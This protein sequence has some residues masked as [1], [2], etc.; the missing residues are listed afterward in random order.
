MRRL[1]ALIF[2]LVIPLM[3]LPAGAQDLSGLSKQQRADT[4]RFAVNN[5]LYTLYH[6]VGHL[7][8]DKLGL[9][10][11][12][13]E[14]DAADNIATW[15]LLG[16][17]TPEANQVLEDAVLGWV[18]TGRSYGDYFAGDDYVSGYSPDRHR[19][20]QIACLMV[21]ADGPA[22]RPLARSYNIPEER[23]RACFYEFDMMDQTLEKLLPGGDSGTRVDVTYHDGGNRLRLAER[24]FRGSGI[25][26]TV[27]DEVRRGY[28]IDGRVKFTARR[29]GEANAFYD[30]G[31]TEIIFCYELMADLM[32]MY[33]DDL[34][35]RSRN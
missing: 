4:L 30:P 24:V 14:E 13:K 32:D 6:E 27:A 11:L 31:T 1:T 29:C 21:G 15:M 8:I 25:F 28:R 34:P 5:G 9:P 7:L 16:K 18:L 10:V 19:A 2:A 23:Q 33:V 17:K 26:D 20:M 35:N 12:G 3:A 22:F